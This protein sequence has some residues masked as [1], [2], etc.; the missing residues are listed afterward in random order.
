MLSA[1][2]G[3]SSCHSRESGFSFVVPGEHLRGPGT[4]G[5]FADLIF[6]SPRFAKDARAYA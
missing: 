2:Q 3:R 6:N 5:E 4:T 1:A